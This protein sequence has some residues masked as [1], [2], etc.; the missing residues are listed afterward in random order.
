MEFVKQWVMTLCLTCVTTGILQM[1][2]ERKKSVSGIK[3]VLA[4]YILVTAISPFTDL[5]VSWEMGNIKT[6]SMATEFNTQQE[7][8]RTAQQTLRSQI[9][10]NLK[11]QGIGADVEVFLICAENK[12]VQIQEIKIHTSADEERVRT[13]V[14]SILGTE[15]NVTVDS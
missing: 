14:Q 2:T 7:I 11:S 15:V 4:L 5:S 8:L 9:Q 10:Q 6:A 13:C 12:D 3:I 1:L